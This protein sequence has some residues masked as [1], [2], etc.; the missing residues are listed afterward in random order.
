MDNLYHYMATST[1]ASNSYA[2]IDYGMYNQIQMQYGIRAISSNINADCWPIKPKNDVKDQK[3]TYG[4]GI[5]I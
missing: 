4:Y 1:S 2:K 3:L 5:N